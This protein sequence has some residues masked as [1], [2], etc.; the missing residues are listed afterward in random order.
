MMNNWNGKCSDCTHAKHGLYTTGPDG[1]PDEVE[2]QKARQLHSKTDQI[3]DGRSGFFELTV[4]KN[5]HERN[6]ENIEPVGCI[7]T[8][9]DVEFAHA[10][11]ALGF[12]S[13]CIDDR[14]DRATGR[15]GRRPCIHQHRK[16]RFH[17]LGFEVHVGE[18]HGLGRVDS[19]GVQR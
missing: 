2:L 5:Q 14:P 7:G 3:A 19:L 4:I 8:A 10:N 12:S 15:S 16:R 17:Y 18:H 13:I 1:K 9:H 6:T 11:S